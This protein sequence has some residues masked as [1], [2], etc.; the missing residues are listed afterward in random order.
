MDEIKKQ[1]LELLAQQY[2][3][4]GMTQSARYI[5]DG[6]LEAQEELAIS[7]I[8]TALS[9]APRVPEGWVL[10]PVKP[11]AEML[12]AAAF[13][14]AGKTGQKFRPMMAA[15]YAA[16]LAARPVQP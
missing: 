1:A 14:V 3:A 8:V 12:Q 5:R 4:A 6:A 2:D 10:A 7:A 13:G 15:G 11:T 16:M 9:A